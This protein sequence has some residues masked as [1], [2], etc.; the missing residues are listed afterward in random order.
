MTDLNQMQDEEL[1]T[2]LDAEEVVVDGFETDETIDEAKSS[3]GDPSEVPEPS[4]KQTS[5]PKTK[6]GMIAAMADAMKGKKKDELTA[7]YE[8][9]MKA[10]DGDEEEVKEETAVSIKEVKK[11]SREDIDVSE[12]VAAIFGEEELSEEFKENATTIFEAAVLSKVNEILETVSVDFESDLEAEK[13]SIVEDLTTKLDDYLEYVAEEWMKDNELAVEQGIRAEIVENF[14]TGLR[15]LFTEN[16]IDIP[17]EKAD[18]VDEMAEKLSEVESSL[19]E[20]M[21]RNI[22]LKKEIVGLKREGVFETISEGLTQTQVEKFSSL[23]EGVD[24]EDEESF[25]TK[26]ETIKENYFPTEEVIESNDTDEEP[27]DESVITEE[28]TTNGSMAGYMNAISR[29]IKK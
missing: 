27:L 12:D 13:E 26:L 25:K 1:E 17:E 23:A 4:T 21:D 16:Y 28:A 14:M 7:A 24:F 29:S 15:D 10:M 6:A 3:F 9:M 18:L 11:L 8:R 20:E 2:V 22:A 5:L 19:S